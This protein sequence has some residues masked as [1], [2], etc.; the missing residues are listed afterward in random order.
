MPYSV[1]KNQNRTHGKMRYS[2]YLQQN[3]IKYRQTVVVYKTVVEKVYHE[4]VKSIMDGSIKH[5]DRKLFEIIDQYLAYIAKR[6]DQAYNRSHTQ[7]LMLFKQ[8]IGDI[9]INE[10][11]R[12]H[13][14]DFKDWRK[15]HSLVPHKKEVSAR[16]VNYSVSVL[17]VFFNW[18]ID[19]EY[20]NKANP[21]SRCKDPEDNFRNI[22]LHSDQ[23]AELLSKAKGKSDWMYTG[24][25]LTLFTGLRRKEVLELKWGDIDLYNGVIN[26]RA[27][28]TKSKKQRT[29]PIP[30]FLETHLNSIEKLGDWILMEN[31]ERV[32][33]DK[34]KYNWERLRDSLS[35][36]CLPNGLTLTFHDLRHVYAQSL[37]DAGINLGDIQAF[38]GHSSVELTVRRYAQRGGIE[39][40]SKVNKLSDVYNLN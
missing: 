23:I 22:I 24:V 31:G 30:D 18:S 6:K 5:R 38:M 11:R 10:I 1:H 21:A 34:F 7:E 16:S 27:G 32:L 29:I 4:W 3:N 40:K 25:M 19:R 36:V 37:R 8:F 15:K 35:F 33:V 28:A 14:I 26:L 12:Y 17:S 2:F 20:Y 9:E 13:I 39:G